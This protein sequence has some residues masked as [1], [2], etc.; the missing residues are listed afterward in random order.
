LLKENK[1]VTM[2]SFKNFIAEEDIMEK[3]SKED[4]IKKIEIK[5]KVKQKREWKKQIK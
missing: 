5:K 1:K 3:W 2:K 4:D